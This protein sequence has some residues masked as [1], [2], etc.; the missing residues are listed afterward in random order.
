[1]HEMN[2]SK[3]YNQCSDRTLGLPGRQ[4]STKLGHLDQKMRLFK[5]FFFSLIAN[6]KISHRSIPKF[7][8]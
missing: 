5:N 6:T 8:K 4:W 2:V 1:M 7:M 3:L